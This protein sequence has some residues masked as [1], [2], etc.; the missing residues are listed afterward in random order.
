MFHLWCLIIVTRHDTEWNVFISLFTSIV[1]FN[2]EQ[3]FTLLPTA[4]EG[5]VFTGVCLS[6]IG[7]MDTGSLLGLVTARSVCILLECFLVKSIKI[8]ADKKR[9]CILNSYLFVQSKVRQLYRCDGSNLRW[10]W[11]TT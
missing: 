5:N 8:E 6:T 9:C 4:R 1:T 2:L 11:T 3:I 7:L 10:Q